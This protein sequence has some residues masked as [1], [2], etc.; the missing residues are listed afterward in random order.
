MQNKVVRKELEIG[1]KKLILETGELAGHANGSVLAT[2]G[3]TV[4]LA[5]AVTKAAAPDVGF[6]PLAVDFEEKLYA[7]GRISSSRFIKRE[8]R[9]SETSILTGRLIDRSIR[10]LFPKDFQAEVQVIITVLSFDGQNDPDI[11]SLIAASAALTISDIPWNG[12]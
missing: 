3:E 8:G 4:V 10:P 2:Y 6:F 7:G 12:P 11:V 1:G 5:T 9:P